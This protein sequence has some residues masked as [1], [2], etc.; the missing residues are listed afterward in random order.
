MTLAAY[1]T[2]TTGL[3]LVLNAVLLVAAALWAASVHWQ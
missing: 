2:V 3:A 1:L